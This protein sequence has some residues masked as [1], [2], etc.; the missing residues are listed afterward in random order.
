MTA[1]GNLS[2]QRTVAAESADQAALVVNGTP[3]LDSTAC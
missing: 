2:I 3:A 1:A